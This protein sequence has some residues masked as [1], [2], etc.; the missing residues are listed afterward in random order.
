MDTATKYTAQRITW[1][2]PWTPAL[3]SF[4]LTRDPAF[5]FT[6]G[7]FARLG[8]LRSG[9]AQ[10]E[11]KE[12][13]V[14]RAYSI[15]SAADADHLEFFSVT[16]PGGEFSTELAQARVGDTVFVDK[17]AYGSLTC[18]RF[19]KGPD[20]WLLA[21]GT[22][23]GPFISI[24]QDPT[25]WRDFENLIV[26]HSVRLPEDLAYRNEIA[27][28]AQTAPWRDYGRTLKYVPIVTRAA[29][30]TALSAHIPQLIE[31]GAL[32]AAVGLPLDRSR[33]RVMLCG[34]P[35]MIVAARQCLTARGFATSRRDAPGQLA[36]EN[37]W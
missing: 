32:E 23:L 17:T 3:F 16:V 27:A 13:F 5:R 22:G 6:P 35:Q 36:V 1:V 9:A 29:G 33:A 37:Y 11:E 10:M 24:L 26:V 14:W 12:R 15:V 31:N 7:Q 19:E 28:L 21:T 18:E 4:R 20:L 8:V 30:A 34:N 25:T 2:Q